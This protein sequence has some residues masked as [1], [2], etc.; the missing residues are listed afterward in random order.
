VASATRGAILQALALAAAALIGAGA[1]VALSRVLERRHY[2]RSLNAVP[3]GAQLPRDDQRKSGFEFQK[4][5]DEKFRARFSAETRD[6]S[7]AGD[8]EGKIRRLVTDAVVR[9]NMTGA[10]EAVEC[11]ATT[12]QV[13]M[14]WPSFAETTTQFRGVLGLNMPCS[15][16][17]FLPE[18]TNQ[19]TPYEATLML[20][21]EGWRQNPPR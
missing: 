11:K 8:A 9:Q 13:A 5:R 19:E 16:E 7:W 17:M 3:L 4:A 21:C 2:N 15:S 1:T 6:D 18:P 10:V 20:G 14:R 12:C